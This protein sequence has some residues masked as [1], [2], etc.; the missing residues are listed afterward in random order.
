MCR[1][2]QAGAAGQELSAYSMQVLNCMTRGRSSV[3]K[4]DTVHMCDVGLLQAWGRCTAGCGR[5][6]SRRILEQ[7]MPLS[8][9]PSSRYCFNGRCIT[10]PHMWHAEEKV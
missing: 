4:N 6:C 10:L 7:G 5:A 9:T 8:W 2:L 3:Q 1:S